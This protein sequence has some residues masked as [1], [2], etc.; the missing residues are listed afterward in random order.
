MQVRS[1]WR[2]LGWVSGLVLVLDQATKLHIHSTFALYE[3][4]P[5]VDNFFN[6]TYVRNSGSAFGL[7]ARYDPDILRVFF[8]AVTVLAVVLLAWYLSRVPASQRLTLWGICLVMGGAVGNG[9]DRFRIGQ[10]IDF[11]DVHWYEVYHWPA[12]NIA[13]SAIC[14]GVGMLLLDAF[15][16][17]RAEP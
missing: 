13:D 17:P 15:R 5:L 4:R 7:L 2:L 10:V 9:V 12:F 14:V 6:L 3:S 16:M 8:P 1:R 11:L